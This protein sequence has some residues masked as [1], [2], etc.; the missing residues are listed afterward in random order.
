MEE[1]A[2]S[3]Y[4]IFISIAVVA[5]IIGVGAGFFAGIKTGINFGVTESKC[6][7][8]SSNTPFPMPSDIRTVT[9]TVK[10]IS[11]NTLVLSVLPQTI[12]SNIAERTVSIDSS[13]KVVQETQKS[14]AVFQKEVN[15]FMK[16][17]NAG[18]SNENSLTPPTPFIEK[19]ASV[20]D[21]VVGMNVVVSTNENV[22]NKASF[23]AAKISIA[24]T[25]SFPI[26]NNPE[27]Q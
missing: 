19:T 22:K 2:K 8:I 1:D 5:L 21:L 13:T 25:T 7:Q 14:S 16:K 27:V 9:G 11:G 20:D 26:V 10:S 3:K 23:V 15:A 17:M 24:D 18:N 12:G 4:V 6:L